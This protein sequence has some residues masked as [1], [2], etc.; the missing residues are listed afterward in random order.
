M[1][2]SSPSVRMASILC[3]LTSWLSN[4]STSFSMS[5]DSNWKRLT[6]WGACR[7]AATLSVD[8]NITLLGVLMQCDQLTPL[9]LH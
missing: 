5:S 9:A 3:K 6:S 4:D 7:V 1:Y 2:I 8:R